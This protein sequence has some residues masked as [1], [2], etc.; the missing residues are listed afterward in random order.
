MGKLTLFITETHE[1]H[2]FARELRIKPP[3]PLPLSAFSAWL[4]QEAPR[5]AKEEVQLSVFWSRNLVE[6]QVLLLAVR[7]RRVC[8][9][10]IRW[11]WLQWTGGHPETFQIVTKL[12]NRKTSGKMQARLYLIRKGF[13]TPFFQLNQSYPSLRLHFFLWKGRGEMARLAAQEK[14][15]TPWFV[16]PDPNLRRLRREKKRVA[17]G[18]FLSTGVIFLIGYVFTLHLDDSVSHQVLP[19]LHR[20]RVTSAPASRGEDTRS[21][22]V[23]RRLMVTSQERMD[24]LA[25]LAWLRKTQGMWLTG[26]QC[27]F[28]TGQVGLTGLVK[29][30]DVLE[31]FSQKIEQKGGILL[32]S[33]LQ[34]DQFQCRFSVPGLCFQAAPGKTGEKISLRLLLAR[35]FVSGESIGETSPGQPS[36]LLS[37]WGVVD[38]PTSRG[39]A[40]SGAEFSS[41]FEAFERFLSSLPPVQFEPRVTTL[42]LHRRSVHESIWQ[43]KL[44]FPNK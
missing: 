35:A 22:S 28:V 5:L 27:D 18:L 34:H 19:S 20:N 26:I 6:R 38:S 14:Q 1:V 43:G 39:E 42:A 33:R 15:W 36:R 29:E 25:L 8:E 31:K 16:L 24:F 32:S 17:L 40:L 13:L 2:F 4:N 21:T 30:E 37:R 7:S 3:C 23:H 10:M 44:D 41:P 11:K 12:R 9:R